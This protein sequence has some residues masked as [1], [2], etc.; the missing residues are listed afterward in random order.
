MSEPR[1]YLLD[2]NIISHMMREPAGRGTQKFAEVAAMDLTQGVVT[3]TVVL[4][5]LKFGLQRRPNRRLSA[6][7]DRILTGVEVFPLD[8]DVVPHY[9]QLRAMLEHNGTPIGPND[10]L[11]AAHALAL[12]AT[13]VSSDT[14][15]S[16]VPGLKVENWLQPA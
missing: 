14:E 9:A 10:T 16:R 6:A 8:I 13:L 11:I 7:L 3:S 5:E 12:D 2:T 1:I 15:F 4:C